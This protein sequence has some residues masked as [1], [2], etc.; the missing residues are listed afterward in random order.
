[1]SKRLFLVWFALLL[2][3]VGGQPVGAQ[4]ATTATF[5]DPPI[6]SLISV[7]APDADGI[8]TVEGAAG[9]VFPVATVAVRNLYTEE[10]VYVT[11]SVTGGF[12]A[13]LYG[14]GNTP[15]L[16]SP[17]QTIPAELRGAVGS[18]PGGPATIVRGSFPTPQPAGDVPVTQ[19]V[20][21]GALSD[22]DAYPDAQVDAV[23]LLRNQDAL[24][25]GADEQPDE[26]A[27]VRLTFTLGSA[28]YQVFVPVTTN[29]TA[30]WEQTAPVPIELGGL[31]GVAVQADALEARLPIEPILDR[32]LGTDDVLSVTQVAYLDADNN[33][34]QA[35]DLSP[36]TPVPAVDEQNG[37]VFLDSPLGEDITH[38]SAAGTVAQGASSWY[39]HGR[40]NA[41]NLQ[42]DDRLTMT[43]DVT[44]TAPALPETLTG[45][46]MV[47][48]VGLLPVNN[49][50]GQPVSGA[51]N[52]S[53]GYATLMTDSGLA[54]ENVQAN[55]PVTE[56][57]V[58][59][60]QVL[61]D[62]DALAFGMVID[63][64]LPDD[65]P[66]GTYVPYIEGFGQIGDGDPF[67][68]N[69]NGLFGEGD[70]VARGNATRLPLVLNVG[71]D[72][73]TSKRLIWTLFQ[74]TPSNGSRGLLAAEDQDRASLSNRVKFNAPTYILPPS[75]PDEPTTNYALEPYLLNMLP[76]AY[77]TTA[78]PLL[79]LLFPNGRLRGSITRPDGS[80]ADL[81]SAPVL[82]NRLSTP[83]LDE[84]DLFGEQSQV[85][86]YRL[87][88]L[89][90]AYTGQALDQYG[91]YTVEMTGFVEDVWGNR[92]E[93][94]GTYN[95]T[96]AETL[97]MQPG[98]LP[99]VPFVAG[100][101]LNTS[102]HVSPGVPADVT[103][104]V[105]LFPLGGGEPVEQTFEG[106]ANA[107]G[108]FQA[109][110]G[111]TFEAPGEYVIDYEARYT[112]AEGRLWAGSLRS[113]GVVSRR[114]GTIIAHGERGLANAE[115]DFTPAWY[116]A[117]QLDDA[118]PED[119]APVLN[120][121]YH[122]GDVLWLPDILG[123]GVVPNIRL[124][125][126]GD[127]YSAWLQRNQPTYTA[128]DGTPLDR[129]DV[130]DALPSRLFADVG[131]SD[132]LIPFEPEQISN[133]GYSYISYVRPGLALRQAVLGSEAETL[134][135]AWSPDD[136]LNRQVGAGSDGTQPLDYVFLFGGAVL[137][138]S[139][140]E[141]A[142]TSAYAALG[143]VTPGDDERGARVFP[144][145][146]GAA[147]GP[148]GGE[149][150]TLNGEPV[151][152]FFVPT[153]SRPGDV[154]TAGD[155]LSIAGQVAPPLASDVTVT[156]TAPSG[157]VRTFSGRANPSGY[158]YA[159]LEDMT[160]N[161]IGAW[162]VQITVTHRGRTSVG[163]VT[164]PYPQG[165]TLGV[166]SYSVYVVPAGEDDFPWRQYD[167]SVTDISP[168]LPFNL[169][170]D[171]PAGWSDVT[172]YLTVSTPGF[173]LQDGTQPITGSQLRYAYSPL[174]LNQQFPFYEANRLSDAGA[175]GADPFTITAVFAG[176]N[177]DGDFDVVAKQV[178]IRYDRLL[179]VE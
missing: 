149:L 133:E 171:P 2:I 89:S 142:E 170:F 58:P 157:E 51:V 173:T 9:A 76:N 43:L 101:A 69:E 11:A 79:P 85:D 54:I 52:A 105:R 5:G 164:E 57:R 21:D 88:T 17:A 36:E 3:G 108:V 84:R 115:S 75:E 80:T 117:D 70:G 103:M 31:A 24:Y 86:V 30:I 118:L 94:G 163:T 62:G 107:F 145:Y 104:R 129:L 29:E 179:A 111:Y 25:L 160:V 135:L 48:R 176:Q 33:V 165:G 47:G 128:P 50:D 44:L 72:A 144:P 120:Q 174:Q 42:A 113:A 55:I 97:E 38:F 32:A 99:G 132:Y 22:W 138:N 41:L 81:S 63:A 18:L 102:L 82:Q 123:T 158:F 143:V 28:T 119:D 106:Q 4:G 92:Y 139:D 116:Y 175:A 110:S 146:R 53:N 126:L 147:G 156:L 96:V 122:S 95:F 74:D 154:L 141:L 87:T 78:A 23:R 61:R 136:P 45:L 130:T 66:A 26:Y 19:L 16:I 152:M 134:P 14:P 68:W 125:D 7:S 60:P 13:R 93:G 71:T 137:R 49:A 151:D 177:T 39:A 37:I 40:T 6:A 155:T 67:R 15:F 73:D 12:R 168:T 56:V 178:V 59:P 169:A 46:A 114:N 159:P 131:T 100:D 10:T 162:Q 140:A 98:T 161:E 167:E 77:N 35:V 172:G 124:Q 8:V 34:L 90:S 121:P 64:P 153:A 109:E 1:M 112:D 91:D 127:T 148:D 27:R 65:L 20:V 166:A 150:F 83:E